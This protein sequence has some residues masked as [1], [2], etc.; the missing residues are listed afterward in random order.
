MSMYRR[1][2][3]VGVCMSACVRACV[4]VFD[5]ISRG[6]LNIHISKEPSILV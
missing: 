1:F 2:V 3:W 5:H 4:R 6:F